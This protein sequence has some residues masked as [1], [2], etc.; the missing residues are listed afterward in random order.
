LLLWYE[1]KDSN[2]KASGKNKKMPSLTI[3]IPV[4]NEEK[5]IGKVLKHLRK[6]SYPK[7]KLKIIVID[8]GSKDKTY[9]IAKK[10]ESSN[11]K[12][13][14]K[15]NT[16]KAGALNFGLKH[17]RT[18]YVA[19]MD[20]DTFLNKNSLRNC[21]KYFDDE[22]VAA[23]TS[24]ILVKNKKRIWGKLQNIE[25]ML[26]ALV[27]KAM[28]KMNIIYATPG[29]LSIYK[30]KILLK[31]G[32]FDEKNLV[33]DVE[34]AWRLLKKGYKI[35]MAFDSIVHSVYPENF[36]NWWR[37]RIRWGIGGIQ[38]FFK[39]FDCFFRKECHGVGNFLIPTSFLTYSF[40]LIGVGVFLFQGIKWLFSNMV[41][42]AKSLLM[43]MNPFV[44]IDIFYMI[45]VRLVYGLLMFVVSLY[46]IKLTLSTHK[47]K[48]N[49]PN[50]ILFL[51]I[52]S[53]L[54][55][56]ITLYSIYKYTRKEIGWL[57]K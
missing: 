13:L 35:K 17:V 52:Y 27:R 38:T 28:E 53:I 10:Y 24:H 18:E 2:G 55:P 56:L 34:I 23:V 36:G 31:V 49:V 26:I 44:R 8:D 15:P 1:N 16:G 41:Y 7:N 46:L 50:L 9:E 32:K 57:T 39:Y 11:L 21:V 29:P 48:M 42:L 22:N 45:D 6:I 3:L 37:Q 51:I 19:V 14:T 4:Y 30:T 47:E 43:G 40:L 54:T 5:I 12:V 33:E 20:G 25:L